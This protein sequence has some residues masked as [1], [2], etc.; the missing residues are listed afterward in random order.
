[1]GKT[2]NT[3]YAYANIAS[4]NLHMRNL[5]SKTHTKKRVQYN[6]LDRATSRRFLPLNLANLEVITNQF[7]E[8]ISETKMVV[9]T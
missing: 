5:E 3:T 4:L 8:H 9:R 2:G 7:L 1:M 6:G